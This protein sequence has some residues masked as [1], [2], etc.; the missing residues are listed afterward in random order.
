MAP[1]CIP[2]RGGEL[3]R[4]SAGDVEWLFQARIDD[5]TIDRSG[6]SSAD[7]DITGQFVAPPG[8]KRP[9]GVASSELPRPSPT[10][11]R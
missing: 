10:P 7:E 3:E 2:T 1:G 4:G 5:G 9:S 6:S 11:S 8:D